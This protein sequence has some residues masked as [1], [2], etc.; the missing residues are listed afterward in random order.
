M[1]ST[2]VSLTEM[3]IDAENTEYPNMPVNP[4]RKL[5]GKYSIV[6]LHDSLLSSLNTE[7]A[8]KQSRL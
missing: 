4:Y 8:S 6:L 2:K 7:V 5:L 1:F 3:L